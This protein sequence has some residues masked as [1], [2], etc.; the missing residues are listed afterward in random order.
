M[1]GSIKTKSLNLIFYL[2]L[3][4]YFNHHTNMKSI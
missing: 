1:L 3:N 4:M 2:A